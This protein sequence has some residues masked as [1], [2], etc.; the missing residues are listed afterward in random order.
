MNG[1]RRP[2]K[3]PW[4]LEQVLKNSP[5]YRAWNAKKAVVGTREA[6]LGPHQSGDEELRLSI[7]GEPGKCQTAERESEGVIVA[8]MDGTT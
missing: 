6:L 4:N 5:A 1:R 3:V 8:M 2:R 7:T